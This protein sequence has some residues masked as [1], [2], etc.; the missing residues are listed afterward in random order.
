MRIA[1]L[2]ITILQAFCLLAMAPGRAAANNDRA[3]PLPYP[4]VDTS[5]DG[6]QARGSR[7]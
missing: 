4:V 6:H 7:T 2:A 1:P 3:G 5:P